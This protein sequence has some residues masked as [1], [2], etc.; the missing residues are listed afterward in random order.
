MWPWGIAG[1]GHC[2]KS[3]RPA[4]RVL[5]CPHLHSSW[6]VCVS[7]PP[8][9]R[10]GILRYYRPRDS[11]SVCLQLSPR[12]QK[13]D[14]PFLWMAFLLKP[15]TDLLTWTLIAES[16]KPC[17]L[18]MFTPQFCPLLAVCLG[19]VTHLAGSQCSH[20][21]NGQNTSHRFVVRIKWHI[22]K[23]DRRAMWAHSHALLNISLYYL[24]VFQEESLLS[25]VSCSASTLLVSHLGCEW[26]SLNSAASGKMEV[27]GSL[28][29]QTL[30]DIWHLTSCI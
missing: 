28:Q 6:S 21:W 2:E 26:R 1:R 12:A 27:Q 20:L 3:S 18:L 11:Q 25:R 8:A 24:A 19:Q 23:A 13:G 14:S 30:C 7:G 4:T 17:G 9:C 10:A 5:N 29:L 22:H 16:N 15:S